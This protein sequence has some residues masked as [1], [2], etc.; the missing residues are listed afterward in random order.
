MALESLRMS[1]SELSSVDQVGGITV[2][3]ED[4]DVEIAAGRVVSVRGQRVNMM[5]E[6]EL[7]MMGRSVELV[8]TGYNEN[9]GVQTSGGALTVGALGVGG[10]TVAS[11]DVVGGLRLRSAEDVE[12][13][14]GAGHSVLVSGKDVL[15]SSERETRFEANSIELATAWIRWL[16]VSVLGSMLRRFCMVWKMCSACFGSPMTEKR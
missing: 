9:V 12:M 7:A 16:K 3:S 1:G 13:A 4:E 5:A 11:S 6:Q 15:I 10:S 2:R 14:A 8:A